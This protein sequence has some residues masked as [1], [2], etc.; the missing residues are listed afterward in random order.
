MVNTIELPVKGLYGLT[1]GGPRRDNLFV[2]AARKLVD[3]TTAQVIGQ[4]TNGSSLYM[5]TGI[6][7]MAP[8]L[9]RMWIK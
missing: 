3:R 9:S 5:I 8:E 1:F 4:I 2:V 6:G 7:A